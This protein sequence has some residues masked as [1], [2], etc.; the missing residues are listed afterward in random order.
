MDN[1]N[2]LYFFTA[3]VQHK[4]FSAAARATGIEKT[5]LS[6]R[7]AALEKRMGTVLL[8]RSTRKMA[9]TQA[10]ERFYYQC[11]PVVEGARFAYDSLAALKS[12]PSGTVRIS[13]PVILAQAYLAPLLPGYM[14]V[15][16]KVTIHL[17]ASD[18]MVDLLED[19]VD[20]ALRSKTQIE[21]STMFVAKVL[22]KVR[23]VMVAAPE[24][25]EALGRP[26][27]VEGLERLTAICR[28]SDYR[29]SMARWSICPPASKPVTIQMKSNLI[30]E[31]MSVQLE[32][33][34]QG[35]GVAFLPGPVVQAALT[36]GQLESV[37]PRWTSPEQILHLI[38][39]KP[40]GTLPSVKSFVHYLL[41]QMPSRFSSR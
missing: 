3:V 39:H 37:L 29:D 2:D 21:D 17:D 28:E 20:V 27:D 35:L 7:V 34:I 12:E 31:D 4:G 32:A 23:R 13:C 40:R 5:R 25:L 18:R 8:R 38:Y 9:L 41:T 19:R 11:Q 33:A 10:G 30:S 15:Y 16:P 6:R 24:Y 14:A 26:T 36:A 1:L 22:A